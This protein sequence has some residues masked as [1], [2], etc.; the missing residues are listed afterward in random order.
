MY[1][2]MGFGDLTIRDWKEIRTGDYWQT[3]DSLNGFNRER[4]IHSRIELWRRNKL[5][6]D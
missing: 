1:F 5:K 3:R 4:F 6:R 2:N